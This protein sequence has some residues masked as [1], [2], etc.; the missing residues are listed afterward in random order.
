MAK[1]K[2]KQVNIRRAIEA[3]EK[4]GLVVARVDVHEDGSVS[5]FTSADAAADEGPNEWDTHL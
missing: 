2:V 4:M 3:V 1:S 5:V